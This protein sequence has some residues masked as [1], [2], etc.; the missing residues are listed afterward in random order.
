MSNA[1]I[2]TQFINTIPK[3]D[4]HCHIDGSFSPEY[5][6]NTLSLS[7]DTDTVLEMLKAPK[8]CKSLTEYLTKF[9]LPIQCLQT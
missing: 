9:D 3:I 5:V 8:D 2:I 6:K 1:N 4:L 7:H